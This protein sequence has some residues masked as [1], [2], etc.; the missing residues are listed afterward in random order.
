MV[1]TPTR[2][3]L[4]IIAHGDQRAVKFF[5]DIGDAINSNG[6]GTVRPATPFQG[7]QHYD[8]TLLKPIWWNGTIWTDAAGLAV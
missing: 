1:D 7:Q 3:A 5:E 8:A 6:I 4:A 2:N